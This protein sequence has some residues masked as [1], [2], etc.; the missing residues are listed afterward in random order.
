MS[1]QVLSHTD[2]SNI[3]SE[4]NYTMESKIIPKR[5]EVKKEDT[6][7][8]ED[9]FPSDDAWEKAF[10][11]ASAY[12][13]KLVS[14]RGKISKEPKALLEYLRLND[15]AYYD[16]TLLYSYAHLNSDVDT[17]NAAYLSM[18]GRFMTFYA[19]VASSCAFAGPEI[20][21]ISDCDMESFFAEVPELEIYRL[22]LSRIRAKRAHML[23]EAEEKLLAE[24]SEIAGAASKTSSSFRN[25]DLRFPDVTD[26]MG[27]S[28]KLT[29]GTYIKYVESSDRTLRKNAFDALYGVYGQFRNTTADF[30]DTQFRQ[31]KFYAN[32]RKY[33]STLQAS[34]FQ[35]EVP[36]EVYHNLIS[37]VHNNMDKMHRYM[38]IRKKLMGLDELHMYDIYPTLV[39]D[40]EV[41]ISYDDAKKTALEALKPLGEE[42]LKVVREGFENRWIDVYENEG[43]RGG[44]YSSGSR[45]HPYMLLN[46][47][48]TLNS[49]FTLVHEMG[50]SMHSYLSKENQPY[51]YSDY[52]IFV[53]EV[54]STCNESLLMSYLLSK[55]TDKKQ[56]AYLI[57]YFLEQFRTTLYRQ[58][59]FAE[60]EMK[61]GQIVESGE[62]LTADLLCKLYHELNEQYYGTDVIIDPEIDIEWARVP[63]FFM[64]YYVFQYATG[65]SA[66][67][68]LS[69]KILTG[70]K[71]DVDKYIGFLSGGSSKTPID[72]LKDAGVDMT[73]TEPIDIA[74][75]TF[76][77]LLDEFEK[78]ME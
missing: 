44:A 63:H 59:M 71:S 31:L 11:D 34:L 3:L 16:L 57:N 39:S 32:A 18:L 50:H 19:S 15:K 38:R 61:A 10:S 58:T 75:N 7:A 48:N 20:A 43:K 55:T 27:I 14:Y 54:A 37:A 45:P 21:S 28:H 2:D 46:H 26:S 72:L 13:E 56:R 5:S 25:A 6:W 33:E 29:Q 23:S 40:A 51:V 49:M 47:D 68:A 76:G 60:F 17:A 8:T 12:P 52:V 53:A 67:M 78:L 73:T 36:T 74:L 42:Y 35:N 9:I 64:N 4:R 77:K 30:L 62:T 1:K 24:V 66:A 65:F 70:S 22:A 69:H 41:E